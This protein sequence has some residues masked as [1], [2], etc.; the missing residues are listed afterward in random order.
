G[1][2][3]MYG[4]PASETIGRKLSVIVP[5]ER[6]GELRAAL[7]RVFKGESVE[8]LETVRR[9]KDGRLV[10]VSISLAPLTDEHGT[11]IAT[12]GISRDMSTAKQAALELRASE[13]RYRSEERRVGKEWRSRRTAAE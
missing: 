10:E 6:A 13:E 1:A 2:E 5:E 3:R 9:R 8:Q 7:D 11:V 12:T 4:Y